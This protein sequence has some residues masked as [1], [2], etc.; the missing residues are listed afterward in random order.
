MLCCKSV[1]ICSYVQYLRIIALFICFYITAHVPH[2][3]HIHRWR[4]T[5]SQQFETKIIHF[6][7]S[8]YYNFYEDY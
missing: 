7:P 1:F 2:V 5:F 3:C 6:M 8:P 4:V